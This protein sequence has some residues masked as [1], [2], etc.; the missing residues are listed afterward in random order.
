MKRKRTKE[1]SFVPFLIITVG[2]LVSIVFF[3]VR[4]SH[5]DIDTEHVVDVYD[6]L[7]QEPEKI[8][9]LVSSAELLA[10]YKGSLKELRTTIE[11]FEGE[12]VELQPMVE[13]SLLSVRVPKDY[14]DIH[15]QTVLSI[16]EFR[17]QEQPATKD[18][19]LEQVNN[20]LEGIK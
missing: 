10:T 3:V 6:A 5:Q 2:L 9:E 1:V 4:F 20:L 16:S 17:K 15:L 19:L 18:Q 11:E 13:D 7:I 12:Q 8:P 14:L